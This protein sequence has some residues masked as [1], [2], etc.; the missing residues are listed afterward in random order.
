MAI[1]SITRDWGIDPSIVRIVTTDDLAA[2]T[3]AGYVTA[4]ADEILALNK[5]AFQWVDTDY[6]LISYDGG[7]GFFTYDSTTLAFVAGAVVPGSLSD[8]L[9]SGHIFVGSA[10]NVAT[11]VAMSGDTTINNTGV[12]A[13]GAGKVTKAMLAAT[14][15]PSH[16]IVFAG[17]PTTVGGA[18]AE[19]F[20]VV[21]AVAAT[22][23][24]YVQMVDNGTNNVTALQAVVTNDTLTVTFSAD[25][26]ND[27]V[28]NYQIIRATA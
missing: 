19:A 7:I 20:A 10:G 16:M 22:D 11:D 26:G 3:T 13:I 23:K 15:R 6:V 14:V 9:A 17:S 8:T 2:I 1:T 27:A 24:A 12:V 18:A 21:G 25:P 4:Q 28:F 5:G